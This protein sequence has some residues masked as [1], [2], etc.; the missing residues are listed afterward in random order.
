MSGLKPR[1]ISEA[2]TTAKASGANT[3]A[4]ASGATTTAKASGATTTAK[5]SGAK[6]DPPP[7]A[8]DD[9]PFVVV[10]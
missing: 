10:C 4:K 9:K 2:K 5:A 3:T 8:K 7:T 6:A 1:P